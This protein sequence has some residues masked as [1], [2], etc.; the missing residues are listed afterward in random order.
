MYVHKPLL[1]S[2]PYDVDFYKTVRAHLKDM[3]LRN[4]YMNGLGWK[5]SRYLTSPAFT[6]AFEHQKIFFKVQNNPWWN[7]IVIYGL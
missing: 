7:Q 1:N 6:S 3:K 2:R 5:K 4:D